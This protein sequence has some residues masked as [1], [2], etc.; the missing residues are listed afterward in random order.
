MKKDKKSLWLIVLLLLVGLTGGYVAS[1]YAKY[2]SSVDK[3]GTATVAKWAFADDNSDSELKIDFTDTYDATTL[4]ND[5]IAPG[6]SGSFD[7]QVVN[8]TSETGVDFTLK[9]K[10][11]DNVP[12]NLK[13]YADSSFSEP[14]TLTA[15][16]ITGQLAAG[17]AT[18]VEVPLYWK[19]EYETL[20]S[21]NSSATGDG[22]DTTD[23]ENANS[24][25]VTVSITGVQ[26]PP[27]EDPI[28]SHIN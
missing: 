24:L 15:G 6:T 3:E 8:E 1:T 7:I 25:T 17:D 23:G 12:T 11:I 18:G 16:T 9:I 19:W 13:F 10:S 26:T 27:S 4:V 14:M 22:A 28:T 21:N 20:D 5:R 2:T